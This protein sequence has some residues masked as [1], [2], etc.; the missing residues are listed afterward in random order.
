L[1]I[2]TPLVVIRRV[3]RS[4][5][6][7]FLIRYAVFGAMAFAPAAAWAWRNSRVQAGS[8]DGINQFRM[9]LQVRPNDPNSPLVTPRQLAR[10]VYENLSWGLI[11]NLPE[12]T[13]PLVRLLS[14]R[15]RR[16]GQWIAVGAS[17]LVVAA[18]VLSARRHLWPLH[19]YL[20]AVLVLLVMFRTGGS[21][22]YFVPV[23]PMTTFLFAVAVR[24]SRWWSKLR[25]GASVVAAIWLAAAGIDLGVAV[26]QQETRPYADT[27]WAE[28]VDIA[29]KARDRLGPEATVCVHNANA[30]AILSGRRT[31]MIQPGMPF[32]LESALQSGRIT[33]VVASRYTPA[34]D[35]ERSGWVRTRSDR[36][37]RVASNTGYDILRWK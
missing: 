25:R 20:V 6:R 3:E 30:F 19:L 24:E 34:R 16:G 9:L 28:F 21:A 2:P 14:L 18:C 17:I 29:L 7:G 5:R 33:H 10:Q 23:A 1:L 11:Y 4:R 36:F 13:V 12:Q 8:V 15:E 32:D 22:R 37:E 35:A 27:H 31:W 26:Y